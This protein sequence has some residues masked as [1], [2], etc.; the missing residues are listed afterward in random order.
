MSGLRE[1]DSTYSTS[2]TIRGLPCSSYTPS[3]TTQYDYDESGNVT[4][5]S[6]NGVATQVSTSST[7]NFAAPTQLTVGSLSS[8]LSYTSFLGLSNVTGPNG[9]SSGTYYGRICP[10]EWEHLALRCIDKYHL[11]Q[12]PVQHV[13]PAHD[14]DHNQWPMDE[15]NARRDRP[16]DSDAIR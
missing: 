6:V 1:W 3:G 13:E 11:Q 16:H 15:A 4:A 8:S 14:Y 10:A 9:D 7:N 12:S 2:L 5:M